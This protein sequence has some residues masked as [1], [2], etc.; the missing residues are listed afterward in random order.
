MFE[1]GITR[2]VPE[3]AGDGGNV[4][5]VGSRVTATDPDGDA[6]SYTITGGA[7]RDAFEITPANR[8]SG[9]ITVKK[10]TELDFEGSQTTYMVEVKATDPFGLN[11]STMV[12]I[13]VTDVN[14]KPELML[15]QA[16]RANRMQSRWM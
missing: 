9:Q 14:E 11:A 10:G 16:T 8:S 6:L 1:S 3:N 7:D 15:S 4:G 13:T 2:E 5:N 12:T